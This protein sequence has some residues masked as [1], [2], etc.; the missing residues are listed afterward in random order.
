[1][2]VYLAYRFLK[3]SHELLWKNRT[4][5]F[6]SLDSTLCKTRITWVNRR[7]IFSNPWASVLLEIRSIRNFLYWTRTPWNL[8]TACQFCL[9]RRNLVWNLLLGQRQVFLAAERPCKLFLWF[10]V[11]GKIASLRSLR[12]PSLWWLRRCTNAKSRLASN[13]IIIEDKAF[14]LESPGADLMMHNNYNQMFSAF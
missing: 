2:R 6:I 3:I 14:R 9:Y 7:R 10:P 1:M 13:A 11:L 5:P 4:R 12:Y 8:P